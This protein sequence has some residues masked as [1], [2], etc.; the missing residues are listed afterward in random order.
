V[1]RAELLLALLGKVL[2]RHQEVEE[3]TRSRV[4]AGI[5]SR[6]DYTRAH[7]LVLRDTASL[8]DLEARLIEARAQL[9]SAL[10]LEDDA[11]VLTE[12]L[13]SPRPSLPALEELLAEANGRRPELR[14]ANAELEAQKQAVRAAQGPYWPQVSLSGQAFAANQRFYPSLYPMPSFAGVQEGVVFNFAVALNVQWSIFDTLTTWTQVRDAQY[15]RDQLIEERKRRAVEVRAEVRVSHGRLTKAIARHK[16]I[17]QAVVASRE[18][19][20]L[21]RKRYRTGTSL[22]IEVLGAE[23]ELTQVESDLIDSETA[24]V[25]AEAD[26][27]R[28]LG[29]PYDRRF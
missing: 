26:L 5:T 22:L 17:Q 16:W 18:S 28:A 8:T 27:L 23:A 29:R 15:A 9:A 3:I 25:Q 19:V 14:L 1:R 21:L 24:I 12:P 11:I 13:E 7:T 10:Q 2:Q 4:D 6:A 20:D